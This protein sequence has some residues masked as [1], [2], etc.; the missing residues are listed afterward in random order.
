MLCFLVDREIASRKVTPNKRLP[1][2]KF[3][4]GRSPLIN[5]KQE[6]HLQKIAFRLISPKMIAS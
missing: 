6:E 4:P 1:P 2:G 3:S 5:L